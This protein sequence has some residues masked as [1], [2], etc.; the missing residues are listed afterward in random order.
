MESIETAVA[1]SVLDFP[2][3]QEPAEVRHL[4]KRC[5]MNY[6]GVVFFAILDRSINIRVGP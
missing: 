2:T 6:A 1:Q 4:A 5:L 3:E